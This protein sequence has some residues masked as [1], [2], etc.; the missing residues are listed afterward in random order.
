MA[1]ELPHGLV[2]GNLADVADPDELVKFAVYVDNETGIVTGAA[3]SIHYLLSDASSYVTGT[4]LMI[5]GGAQL[6][7]S[8]G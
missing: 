4:V 6:S 3:Q 1:N 8:P 5:D 2:L 7:A